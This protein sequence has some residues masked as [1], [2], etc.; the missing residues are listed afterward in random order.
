MKLNGAIV[1][2]KPDFVFICHYFPPQNNAGIRRI[3]YWSNSLAKKG[4]NVLVITSK[5]YKKNLR[6]DN[7]YSDVKICDFK[8]GKFRLLNGEP[9]SEE[10]FHFEVEDSLIKKIL[11]YIKRNILNKFFGQLLDPYLPSNLITSAYLIFLKL[12]NKSPLNIDFSNSYFIS[13]APPWSIHIIGKTLGRINKRPCFIDYRDQFY[14]NHMFTGYFG[15]LEEMID[16]NLCK[17]T[18]GVFAISPSMKKHYLNYSDNVALIPNGFD[19]DLFWKDNKQ[20]IKSSGTININ[21]FGSIQHETRLPKMLIDALEISGSNFVLNFYGNVP[22]VEKYI[23]ENSSL[24][25]KV[26]IMGSI[27]STDVRKIMAS[28]DINLMCE[29]IDGDSLSHKGVMT[30]KLYEYLAVERPILALISNKSDMCE[31]LEKSGLLLG[32]FT[33]FEDLLAWLNNFNYDNLH[34]SPNSDFISS[35]SRE[36]SL[37]LLLRKAKKDH[38]D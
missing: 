17:N 23:S 9:V 28:S 10:N 16:K 21:Y 5:K 22:L 4:F 32:Q 15:C 6:P 11:L 25:N 8:F 12:M 3:L 14:G 26:K 37:N 19:P 38:E 13:S 30:S 2:I 34:I 1:K 29:T 27:P 35:F 24:E 7:V 31:V 33:I 18:T 20:E 36:N